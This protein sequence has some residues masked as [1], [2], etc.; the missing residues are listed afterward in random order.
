MS[1]T[2]RNPIYNCT[3]SLICLVEEILQNH[4]SILL[5]FRIS[6]SD[7]N[8]DIFLSWFNWSAKLHKALYK[9]RYIVG[10]S[11]CSTKSISQ[12][13]TRLLT[14]VKEGHQMYCNTAY[15][16]CGV[17]QTWIL[18]KS[19]ELFEQSKAQSLYSVNNIY[20]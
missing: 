16:R 1:A 13:L 7:D 15:T 5:S 8:F 3:L 4:H 18:N 6:L 17:N 9:Q 10:S 14:A 11:K 12:I 19:T 20:I 2:T